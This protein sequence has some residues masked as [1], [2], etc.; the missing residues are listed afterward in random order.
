MRKPTI[1]QLPARIDALEAKVKELEART[2][3]VVHH[4]IPAPVQPV[5]ERPSWPTYPW[6]NPVICGGGFIGGEQAGMAHWRIPQSS[7]D[8]N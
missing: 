8:G 6:Q 7:I 1:A 3:S 5:Y 4:Y 2:P